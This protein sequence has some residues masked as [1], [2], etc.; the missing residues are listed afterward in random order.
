MKQPI[1]TSEAIFPMPVLLISTY[2]E[3]GSID[4]MNAAWGTMM[5]RDHVALNLT[6]THKTVENINSAR[7]LSSILPM[8]HMR[9][10]QTGSALCPAGRKRT[11]LPRA[12]SPPPNHLWWMPL[13]SMSF[14]LLLNVN[15]L[16]IKAMKRV[17]A[18]SEK[19]CRH[20]WSQT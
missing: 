5:D 14:Q 10:K 3:D 11:S 6:E 13:S 15:L 16:N 20:R 2:N 18:L 17:L 1:K 9:W 8:L 7:D 19:S 12:D 4:V